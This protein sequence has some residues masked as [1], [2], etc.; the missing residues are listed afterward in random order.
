MEKIAQTQR[1]RAKAQSKEDRGAYIDEEK[2][3]RRAL[4]GGD[5][6]MTE[7]LSNEM[8]DL[9]GRMTASSQNM[10]SEDFE[11]RAN[12]Y[13][14]SIGINRLL[15]ELLKAQ[16]LAESQRN[17]DTNPHCDPLGPDSLLYRED[18]DAFKAAQNDF[19]E[20]QFYVRDSLDSVMGRDGNSL[21][22]RKRRKKYRKLRREGMSGSDSNFK[23]Y[24]KL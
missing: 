19:Y 12:A 17:P 11:T 2:R 9:T 20:D 24:Y 10:I 13:A 1:A 21:K 22:D 18:A 23:T 4:R 3:I 16:D 7:F 8:L 14:D 5:E 15:R 6:A